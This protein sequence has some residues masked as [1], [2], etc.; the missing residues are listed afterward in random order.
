MA[1]FQDQLARFDTVHHAVHPH[2]AAALAFMHLGVNVQRCEQR[3]KRAGGSVHHKG[4]I[5]PLV[6][7]IALLSFDVAVFFMDLRGLGEACL[8]FMHGLG[9]QNPRVVFVQ[10]QQQRRAVGHHRDKLLVTHPGGV[11]QD[12]ITQVPNLIHHL[13]GVVDGAI[14]SAELDHRQTERTRI[15]RTARCNFGHQLA[16]VLFFKTVGV[17]AADKAVRVA[18]G[19]QI[20]RRCAC[21]E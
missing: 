12:V 15:A 11:K 21:L 2:V 6:R 7:D 13:T 10:L 14:V 1:V 4:I 18:R 5:Q 19:F 20:D 3:I 8:L 17:N 9:N 16:Q